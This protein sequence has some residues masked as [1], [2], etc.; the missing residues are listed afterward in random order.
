MESILPIEFLP[1]LGNQLPDFL[2]KLSFGV[3]NPQKVQFMGRS[4]YYVIEV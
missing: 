2:N 1:R 4:L 3:T